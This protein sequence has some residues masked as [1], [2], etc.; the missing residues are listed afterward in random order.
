MYYTYPNKKGENWTV[1]G[2]NKVKCVRNMF[3]RDN[4][5]MTGKG[6]KPNVHKTGYRHK[7]LYDKIVWKVYS[8]RMPKRNACFR[9]MI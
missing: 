5:I 4:H 8:R 6:M 2:W 9:I 1:S 3:L 7:V